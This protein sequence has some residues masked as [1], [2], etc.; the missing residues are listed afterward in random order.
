[1]AY[2]LV[3]SQTGNT[4]STTSTS[5]S[6]TTTA[7]GSGNLLVAAIQMAAKSETITAPAGWTLISNTNAGNGTASTAMFYLENSTAGVT[8]FAFSFSTACNAAITF[9]EWSGV[10]TSGAL[11]TSVAAANGKTSTATTGTTA[12]LAGTGELAIW[13][14]GVGATSTLTYSSVL[15]SYVED[16]ASNSVSTASTKMEVTFFHNTA[17]GAAATSSGCTMSGSGATGNTEILAVFK[18]AASSTTTNY[19][20]VADT[21]TGDLQGTGTAPDDSGSAVLGQLTIPSDDPLVSDAVALVGQPSPS[22]PALVMDESAP[23]I[24]V[25]SVSEPSPLAPSEGITTQSDYA[26]TPGVLT[27]S[28][29]VALSS[30]TSVAESVATVEALM[31]AGSASPLPELAEST[32]TAA[33]LADSPAVYYHLNE[34]NGTTVYDRSGNGRNGTVNGTVTYATGS[35]VADPGS[36]SMQFDGSTG[37]V[38]VP[39]SWCPSGNAAWTMEGW[40]YLTTSNAGLGVLINF[41]TAATNEEPNLYVQNSVLTQS[42][43]NTDQSVRTLSLNT[44]YHL[45]TTYNGTTQIA[46]INGQEIVQHAPGTVAVPTS[47][48]ACTIARNASPSEYFFAGRVQ[49]A[50]FYTTA[51]SP[52]RIA[53]HYQAGLP[54]A[55][56]TV[57]FSS[58]GASSFSGTDSVTLA[59]SLALAGGTS[60]SAETVSLSDTPTSAGSPSLVE[61]VTLIEQ[62]GV[63]GSA[64]GAGGA[65]TSDSLSLAEQLGAAASATPTSEQLTVS[66]QSAGQGADSLTPETVT[67]SDGTLT[68]DADVFTPAADTVSLTETLGLALFPGYTPVADLLATISE[69]AVFASASGLS[70]SAASSGSGSAVGA[71]VSSLSESVVATEVMGSAPA[72]GVSESVTLT[73][74]VSGVVAGAAPSLE[75]LTLADAL[76]QAHIA[77]TPSEAVTLAEQVAL[78]PSYTP[79]TENLLPGESLVL[80]AQLT[81]QDLLLLADTGLLGAAFSSQEPPLA[82]SDAASFTALIAGS[83]HFPATVALGYDLGAG[84]TALSGGNDPLALGTGSGA[85]SGTAA[86]TSQAV[87][88][89]LPSAIPLGAG[90]TTLPLATGRTPVAGAGRPVTA[91]GNE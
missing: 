79:V 46:Y 40:F 47:G 39:T 61:Q 60:S 75:T 9:E 43:W 87:A 12:A 72:V 81:P 6:V 3:Q 53:A 16:T 74:Q 88:L 10:A 77:S 20:P 35:A 25:V 54:P 48:I 42:T 70:E 55:A 73:D 76:L 4:G 59:D 29:S 52:A 19:S 27:L 64:S 68:N 58:N 26:P 37:Y 69:G 78:Q 2:T 32:Y 22:D 91:M 11:D 49:E 83:G 15:N 62:S 56:E 90:A 45:A 38:S 63:A 41:G 7:T 13:C 28:D 18:P 85:G 34:P 31:L 14:L 84:H 1:M 24:G 65:S 89:A 23:A 82:P 30:T 67:L 86:D 21:F 17:V 44:W 66:E 51:L 80:G 5:V 71:A 57:S 36:A 50:A 8:S 33:V